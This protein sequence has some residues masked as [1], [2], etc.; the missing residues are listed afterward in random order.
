MELYHRIK[1]QNF[2]FV[3]AKFNDLSNYLVFLLDVPKI[4]YCVYFTNA[5]S[6]KP[7]QSYNQR[8][9]SSRFSQQMSLVQ[10]LILSA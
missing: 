9:L 7:S 8:T 10:L 6:L 1:K 3:S 5:N 4:S 2:R